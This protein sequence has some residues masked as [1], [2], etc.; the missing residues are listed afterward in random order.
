MNNETYKVLGIMSG[1][2][3]DG[4]DFAY[5]VF[6]KKNNNWSFKLK[7][8]DFIKYSKDWKNKL[9]GLFFNTKKL[10]ELELE[11][12]NFIS[13][14]VNYFLKKNNLKTDYISSHGH[15]IFHDPKNGVTKQI[16]RGDV[17]YAKTNI[18]VICNFRE[19]D[20]LFGGQG[21]PLVPYGDI[22]LFHQ[23]ESCLNLGGFSNISFK[24]RNH[25]RAFDICPVNIVL[26][27]LAQKKGFLYD[28]NGLHSSKGIIDDALLN[29]LN[30]TTVFKC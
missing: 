15:T 17:I 30:V 1:T 14:K 28:K 2:S 29:N 16:G 13:K 4:L 10:E 8:Y 7:C 18:P 26:N 24:E 22:F 3:L 11:Y 19:Q 21:A 27:Y 6:S 25:I 23:Y 20:V 9:S 5:C 12:S